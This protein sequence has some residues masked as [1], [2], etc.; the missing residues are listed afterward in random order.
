MGLFQGKTFE[1]CKPFTLNRSTDKPGYTV[2]HKNTPLFRVDD[3]EGT[4][5]LFSENKN[6]LPFALKGLNNIRYR[7]YYDWA[8]L[9]SLNIAREN[10]KVLLN[11]C[12]LSQTDRFEAARVSRLLSVEDRYWIQENDDE[13]WEDFDMRSVPLSESIAV[14]ALDGKHITLQGDIMTP[15]IT[16]TGSFPQCWE[17]NKDGHLY[18]YKKSKDFYESEHEV[19]VSDILDR[20]GIDH[21]RYEN[22]PQKGD[23][24]CRC[25]CMTEDLSRVTYSEFEKYCYNRRIDPVSWVDD[26]FE[27]EFGTMLIIDY[28]LSNSDRHGGNWGFLYNDHGEI[29]KMHPLMDQNKSFDPEYSEKDIFLYQLLSVDKNISTK[30]LAEIAQKKICID[31][32]PVLNDHSLRTRFLDTNADYDLFLSKCQ[33]MQKIRWRSTTPGFPSADAPVLFGGRFDETD[34]KEPD[35]EEDRPHDK[36]E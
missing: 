13:K 10:A 2:M 30:K 34:A 5:E 11:T 19:I 24:I 9:R 31:F 17:R 14:M 3:K 26:H 27:K 4:I 33:E 25:R 8:S 20:L 21:I 16:N 36:Y 23:H 12:Y 35:T 1:N 6:L 29:V 18:L 28:V 15:E 7:D 32:S 22:A